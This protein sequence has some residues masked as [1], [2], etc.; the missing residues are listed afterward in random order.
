MRFLQLLILSAILLSAT[1]T[2]CRRPRHDSVPAVEYEDGLTRQAWSMLDTGAPFDEAFAVQEEAVRLVREGR[3]RENP[4][5]ALEQMAYFL[6]SEGRL[7]E[8]FTYFN[9]AEDSLANH[10]ELAASESAIMLFGDLSQFYE[11]LGMKKKAVEYSDSAMS[12][13]R[14]LGGR[15]MPDL[16]RFRT[17]IFANSSRPGEAFACLDSAN[18]SIRRYSAPED[19]AFM[20]AMIGCERANI[21][22]SLNP[23]ADSLA[24]AASILAHGREVYGDRDFTGFLGPLGYTLCRQ[25]RRQEGIEMME[26]AV[27]QL[28]D[29]GDLEMLYMEM[30][31][32]LEVYTA[33]KMYDKVSSLYKEYTLLGD[34]MT[35]ARHNLDLVTAKV[36]SDVAAKQ[37]ENLMLREKLQ[38]QSR[39]KTGAVVAFIVVALAAVAVLI[40]MRRRARKIRLSRDAERARRESAE[41][42]ISAALD[43]RN[44]ALERIE[45]IRNEMTGS[46]DSDILHCPQGLEN[47]LGPFRRTFI[48]VY[49]RFV[50]DL[51]RDYP[52][53]TDTDMVFCMLIFLQHSTQEI[54]ASL[55]ISRASVNS[56]RYRLRSKLRLAKEES[57]DQFLQSRQG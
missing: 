3:S 13:S 12:A 11:R 39:Q 1:F 4:V 40:V 45:A 32:L 24:L 18:S 54:S 49:P 26:T 23:S 46:I 17:Q 52:S 57:L 43:E 31:R 30:R 38:A 20:L 41:A 2:G 44:S 35:R 19:T 28:R 29:S 9:E 27:G 8:A 53:L 56:A 36:R 47:N 25:G 33:G 37:R 55:N 16:W 14:R 5:A 51:R 6:F 34:S 21:I 48:A 15:L 7:E 42:G 10:P 50:D 22:L